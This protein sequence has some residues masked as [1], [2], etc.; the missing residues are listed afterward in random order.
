[1]S[2]HGGQVVGGKKAGF[3]WAEGGGSQAR[4][5][6]GQSRDGWALSSRQAWVEAQVRMILPFGRVLHGL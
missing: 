3:G 2:T 5:A 6:C 4:E 1:M